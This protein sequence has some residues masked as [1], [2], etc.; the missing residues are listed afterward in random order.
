MKLKLFFLY[1]NVVSQLLQSNSYKK[2]NAKHFLFAWRFLFIYF[3]LLFLQQK[4]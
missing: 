3:Y 1:C 2:K 4:K